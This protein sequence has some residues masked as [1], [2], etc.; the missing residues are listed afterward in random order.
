MNLLK[1]IVSDNPPTTWT[2]LSHGALEEWQKDIEACMEDTL[3]RMTQLRWGNGKYSLNFQPKIDIIENTDNYKIRAEVPGVKREDI[4]IELDNN[5]LR[6]M[7]EKHVKDEEKEK[8]FYRADC[9]Y[10]KFMQSLTLPDN[11]DH[12]AIHADFNDGVL[13][14]TVGKTDKPRNKKTIE[15]QESQ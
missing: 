12:D 14:I 2:T 13:Q 15:V 10:G 5:I 9:A 7:G 3:Q 6:I 1:W 8:N 4:Q 11:V